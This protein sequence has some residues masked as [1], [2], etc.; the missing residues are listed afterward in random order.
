MPGIEPVSLAPDADFAGPIC[1]SRA[2][3]YR[4]GGRIQGPRCGR[5]FAIAAAVSFVPGAIIPKPGAVAAGFIYRAA[6]R[7]AVVIM[8][9]KGTQTG[10]VAITIGTRVLRHAN[11]GP[12]TMG[13]PG[14][15]RFALW[16]P[17]GCRLG[18]GRRTGSRGHDLWFG[19][20][21]GGRRRFGGYFR[22]GRGDRL[23][24]PGRSR[25]AGGGKHQDGCQGKPSGQKPR[26]GHA[27]L[28]S[29]RARHFLAAPTNGEFT[30]SRVGWAACP[31]GL[32]N[33]RAEALRFCANRHA[34]PAP[35]HTHGRAS[36]AH[37]ILLQD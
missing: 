30:P 24:G 17:A 20:R 4:R 7:P 15:L 36:P 23:G 19:F 14:G 6:H 13:C 32:V 29:V 3:T 10:L 37:Q 21:L 28:H 31:E 18:P 8:G 25:V 27:S 16:R 5:I 34:R 22:V 9:P 11:T 2:I 35:R 12:G 26:S 1:S 33:R